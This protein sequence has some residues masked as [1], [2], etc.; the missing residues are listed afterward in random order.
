M[1]AFLEGRLPFP[2]IAAVIEEVLDAGAAGPAAAPDSL[3]GVREL[4]R[5]A[6]ER[7][8]AEVAGIQ[9]SGSIRRGNL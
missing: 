6:R 7:G 5:W 3:A 4:D 2:G 1:A 8:A 9:S